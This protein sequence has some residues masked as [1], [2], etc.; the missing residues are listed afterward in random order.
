MDW[1]KLGFM[2]G[3]ALTEKGLEM[4][5][6]RRVDAAGNAL[7]GIGT[8]TDEDR[9]AAGR[10]L[11][12]V[13]GEGDLV[14]QNTKNLLIDAK[15]KWAQR[16]N[17]IDYW[18]AHGGSENDKEVKQWRAEQDDAHR[19]AD[20]YR[21]LAAQNGMDLSTFGNGMNLSQLKAAQQNP[22]AVAAAQ[23]PTL[24]TAAPQAA[25]VP[26]ANAAGGQAYPFLQP[27]LLQGISRNSL[28]ADSQAKDILQGLAANQP[29]QTVAPQAVQTNGIAPVQG[30]QTAPAVAAPGNGTTQG[31]ALFLAAPSSDAQA[32]GQSQAAVSSDTPA[33]AAAGTAPNATPEAWDGTI[34]QK[35]LYDYLKQKGVQ[36]FGASYDETLDA[37]AKK[38]AQA[39]LDRMSDDEI[40]KD[41]RVQGFGN[42][43]ISA[44]LQKRAAEKREQVRKAAIVSMAQ[45]AGNPMQA[46]MLAYYQ[47]AGIDPKELPELLKSTMSDMRL[48]TID[49]GGRINAMYHDTNGLGSTQ[50]A[51]FIRS[52]SPKEAGDL[53]NTNQRI[54]ADY[55]LGRAE[56]KLRDVMSQRDYDKA[57]AGIKAGLI[58]S[59]EDNATALKVA[60]IRGASR[61]GSGGGGSRG[62]SGS[63]TNGAKWK[64]IADADNAIQKYEDWNDDH[65]DLVDQGKN[66]FADQADDA[67]DYVNGD[68]EYYN[69]GQGY[70]PDNADDMY[71]M[72]TWL[73]ET[74]DRRN[75]DKYS[76]EELAQMLSSMGGYGPQVAQQL[77]DDGYF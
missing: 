71:S 29:G 66:P 70:D 59:Q 43:I 61:P 37:F 14:G 51:N 23:V 11:G 32:E 7:N 49:T 30:M 52:L 40:R 68:G 44:V 48:D 10:V 26:A 57:M 21:A 22:Q 53:Q 4:D 1:E 8:P 16:Q 72:A 41:L 65:P 20:F 6:Q 24:Q 2:V 74:N 33:P 34:R 42:D 13:M 54:Q 5:H 64:S 56:L 38:V 60:A 50:T 73:K 58:K 3:N 63:S 15:E 9:Q 69:N 47:A 25:A 46:S 77:L 31:N 75:S 19:K 18:L 62:G 35:D 27:D 28:W 36:G 55:A 17:D 45:A 12:S 76:P 67:I 39:R